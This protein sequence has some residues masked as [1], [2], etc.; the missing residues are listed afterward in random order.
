MKHK[1]YYEILE[2]SENASSSEIKRAYYKLCKIYHPDI[3]PNTANIFCNIN[4]AYETLIDPVKRKQYDNSLKSKSYSTNSQQN[5][6]GF[7]ESSYKHDSYYS[8]SKYYQDPYKEPI[9]NIL[10]DLK[11]YRF[12]NAIHAIWNRNLF[13]IIGNTI[14]CLIL[15]ITTISNRIAKLFKKSLISK[16]YFS[17]YWINLIFDSMKANTL[18]KFVSWTII[19]STITILKSIYIIF[20]SIGFIWNQIIRPMLIPIAIILAASIHSNNKRK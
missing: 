5:N 12:E 10:D 19:L 16:K 9:L 3:N 17:S 1:N 8:N 18:M 6:N 2:I 13:I 4:E 7:Y 15:I 11:Y 20:K 14:I